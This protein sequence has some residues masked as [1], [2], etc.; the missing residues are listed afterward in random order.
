MKRILVFSLLFIVSATLFANNPY[1]I[2]LTPTQPVLNILKV[3]YF[4]PAE[5]YSQ[6]ILFNLRTTIPAKHEQDMAEKADYTLH[7]DFFWNGNP[8]SGTTLEPVDYPSI[9]NDFGKTFLVTNRDVITSE[10]NRFYEADGDFSFDD[11]MDNNSQFKDFV[12]ETGRLPDGNYRINIALVPKD[13]TLYDGDNTSM[14]FSVRGI[15][16]VRLISPGVFAGSADIPTIFNP[17]ILNWT[18]SGFNNNFVVEIKEFDQP[19]ELDP[20]NIENNG[21][22][23]ELEEI[24]HLTVYN[25]T[26]SFLD[27]KYYA[28]RVKVNFVGEESLN[29][30]GHEQFL[31]SN[32]NV[33]AFSCAPNTDVPNAFQA[34]FL[35]SLKGLNIPEINSLLEEGYLPK[36]GIQLNGQIH[37]GKDAVNKLRKLFMTYT[38]D[39]SVE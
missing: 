28:W 2:T 38:I 6:P 36:D 32:Y 37:Y 26:Y 35:Q 3:S 10:D 13:I 5:S 15:Q 18:T 12:L 22:V 9:S 27:S 16:S 25:P 17:I 29:Q 21:R 7:I 30:E 39:V 4:D 8:L 34:E 24:S 31:A 1:S 11:I 23:V 14:N 20:S 19:Y 33:F